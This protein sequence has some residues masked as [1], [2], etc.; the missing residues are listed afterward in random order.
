M[1]FSF[2]G[3]Q[4]QLVQSV[5]AI[6]I[7]SLLL[8]ALPI[9]LSVAE[10]E[11]DLVVETTVTDIEEN[12]EVSSAEDSGEM[13]TICKA[14]SSDKN[15]YRLITVNENRFNET[16]ENGI[17]VNDIVP[18]VTDIYP[19]G[20]NW[21][22]EGQQIWEND[23]NIPTPDPL[24]VQKC[25][26][27]LTNG[28]FEN[29]TV[30]DPAQW[31]R[32]AVVPGW[33]VLKLS[34]L[35]PTTLE[36]H[37][38][39]SNNA[40]AQGDQYAELDADHA[41]KISQTVPT[42][43]G[44]VYELSW[45]FAPRHDIGAE[46]NQ[47]SVSVNDVVVGTNGPA[48]GMAGL[49]VSDWQHTSI[50]FTATSSATVAFADMG[51]SD[52]Y[53]TFI[54]NAQLCLVRKPLPPQDVKPKV[55]SLEGAVV[56][57]TENALK[58]NGDPVDANR[59]LTTALASAA[60][61]INYFG[62]E[63]DDWQV[64]PLDF[65]TLGIQGELVYEFNGKVAIDRPGFDITV[66]EITGGPADE[67]TQEKA[68]VYVSQ[69]G[70]NYV[71]L[72]TLTGDG[73]VDIGPA[74]LDFVKYVKLVDDSVGVQGA[75]GDGYD[76]D[77]I[78]IAKGACS[79]YVTIVAEKIVC[80]DEA[81]LPNYG[82]GGPNITASTAAAW[83]TDE[84]PSCRLAAD[85][86]FEWTTNQTNDPGDSRIG[87][88]GTPWSTFAK[89]NTQGV[90]SVVLT[91]AM[92]DKKKNVWMREVLKDGFIGFSHEADSTN[93]NTVSAEFYCHTDVLNFDNRD[94]IINVVMGETYHCVAWNS[95]TPKAPM[96][97][98]T[99]VS[100]EMTLVEE[101]NTFAVPTYTH[102][103]W[104]S[105][106][107]AT[108]I[109][110]TSTVT[111]PEEKQVY[112]FVDT[113][114]VATP[115]MAQI[116]I[117]ADNW[118]VL[119]V[120]G[121]VVADRA[122][123]NSYL[124]FQKKTFDISSYVVTGENTLRVV[125]TNEPLSG[126]TYKTN[127]AGVLYKLDVTGVADCERTTEP[128]KT[129]SIVV[130]GYKWN[131]LN[132][133]GVKTDDEP[134]LSDWSITA[135]GTAYATTTTTDESGM[136]TFVLPVDNWIVYE[137]MQK[138]WEQTVALLNGSTTESGVCALSSSVETTQRCDFGNV[139]VRDIDPEKFVI[140]GYKWNDL[141]RDGVWSEGEV[142]LPNWVITI[143]NG[144]ATTST[145]TDSTG[146][147]RFAVSEGLWTV[148]EESKAG[149]VQ[150]AV[151]QNGTALEASRCTF[152]LPNWVITDESS[153]VVDYPY[154]TEER[155]VFGNV[156]ETIP[157][158][159]SADEAE[160]SRQ[161]SGTRVLR[162]TL[163]T[164]QVLGAS[165]STVSCPF[166]NTYMQIGTQNNSWEVTKLQMFLSI[167]MGFDTP[168]TGVFDSATDAAVKLFQERYRS[169][170]LDPWY[171]KGIVPHSRPTGFVYKTT[172]WKI[173]DIVCP[174]FEAYP[175]FE[176]ED[177]Q[178]NVDID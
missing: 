110:A 52:S 63:K 96:C 88:A 118:Y 168:V 87:F 162:M 29:P 80:D 95:P 73:S 145:T 146:Y 104:T 141:N 130:T 17:G 39:W 144:Y 137:Q 161:V 76:V 22:P 133:D 175:S 131:D 21:T 97:E 151:L 70:V 157:A 9:S 109:W 20:K 103:T 47:L 51:P 12:L 33:T 5:A 119:Y 66:W 72:A 115:T 86:Q 84:N 67:Q 62:Q 6:T 11:E 164:P 68:K 43:P 15:P 170:I 148:S 42:I 98:M 81:D 158:E 55:C 116:T 154:E 172:R 135:S 117:A 36:L 14:T 92:L 126:S 159:P 125:V 112:T 150:T 59:R 176:N 8:S 49:T 44:G 142:G 152:S 90:T 113:F 99:I 138:G 106:P 156:L 77:A 74:G 128:T 19:E 155:C 139:V 89:T 38:G 10:A 1:H 71:Y 82:T 30:T 78:T 129:K 46:Q 163:P 53:G 18:P 111:L 167:V 60:P 58:N 50:R 166:L 32:F 102:N 120:N 54:D 45:S 101:T 149:W 57:V 105:I 2:S 48:T 173:N 100:D 121:S 160:N 69:D 93:S 31:E 37:R 85:W 27:I 24:P 107:G 56:S 26:N 40:A 3:T 108:W 140:D 34:D 136:Y 174:G 28:S 65:F 23:C 25:E 123:T 64:N 134:T 132:R 35:S 83:I 169:E 153:E 61:Y 79:E 165:T 127:P 177:L 13:V 114:T 16:N 178:Q 7:I 91:K 41:T 143:S 94:V 75:N 4:N 124:D 122:G 147:Y 171:E